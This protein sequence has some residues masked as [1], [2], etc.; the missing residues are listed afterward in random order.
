[1]LASNQVS[2]SCILKQRALRSAQ[3]YS[4]VELSVQISDRGVK[5]LETL[6]ESL[7]MSHEEA[8]K[9]VKAQFSSQKHLL[10]LCLS[11]PSVSIY[12]CLSP[13]VL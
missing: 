8:Q 7:M 10:T 5:E 4:T 12:R 9:N 6:R 2:S 13:L 1:M 3:S 11:F